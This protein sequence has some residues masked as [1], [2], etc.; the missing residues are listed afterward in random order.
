[1]S[2]KI[3]LSS[4]EFDRLVETLDS[5]PKFLPKLAELMKLSEEVI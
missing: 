4:E 1:M 3:I 5:E 2:E